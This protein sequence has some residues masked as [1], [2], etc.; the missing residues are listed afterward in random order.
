MRLASTNS[1]AVLLALARNDEAYEATSRAI[2]IAPRD[3]T[4]GS[5]RLALLKRNA[6]GPRSTT[7]APAAST[8]PRRGVPEPGRALA[9]SARVDEAPSCG[10]HC[11]LSVR[12]IRVPRSRSRAGWPW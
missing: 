3:A 10:G 2:E 5:T 6:L 1:V 7:R 12:S 4:T 8:R 11:R 9:G